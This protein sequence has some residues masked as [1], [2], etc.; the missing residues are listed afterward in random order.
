MEMN[1]SMSTFTILLHKGSF[2]SKKGL[3]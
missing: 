1:Q 2:P 3:L